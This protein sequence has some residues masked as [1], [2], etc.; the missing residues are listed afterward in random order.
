MFIVRLLDFFSMVG[1]KVCVWGGGGGANCSLL[2]FSLVG[3]SAYPKLKTHQQEQSLNP[4][5]EKQDFLKFMGFWL[6]IIISD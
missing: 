5:G 1:G 3:W 6:I 4:S 2:A